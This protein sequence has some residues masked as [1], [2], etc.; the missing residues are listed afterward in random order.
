MF[1][2]RL[3]SELWTGE[4]LNE[5]FQVWKCVQTD[6]EPWI[7]LS[8]VPS[9]QH[10]S[11]RGQMMSV[12]DFAA[13]CANVPSTIAMFATVDLTTTPEINRLNGFKTYRLLELTEQISE[14]GFFHWYECRTE[15]GVF[16]VG[17]PGELMI[18]SPRPTLPPRKLY[19]VKEDKC[20]KS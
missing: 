11:P 1:T 20:I 16:Y 12:S 2:T 4:F 19:S 5:G 7:Q 17:Q 6:H 8:L 10:P 14:D 13:H 3:D 18:S 9:V 15:G